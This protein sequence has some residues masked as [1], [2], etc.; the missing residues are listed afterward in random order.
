[1]E[2]AYMGTGT[3]MEK[4]VNARLSSL[5]GAMAIADL[6]KT[7]L[8]PKGMDKILQSVDPNDQSISVTNDGA[9]ILSKIPLDNAAAKV[10]V[11]M[12]KV[13]DN[14]VG[15]GTTSVAVLC[16]E[17]LR[18]AEQLLLQQRIHPQTICAG[19]RLATKE[20]K[21]A[22]ESCASD[23]ITRDDLLKIASTTLSSKL[24]NAEKKHFAELC[25]SAVE[26]LKGSG[27]LDHIQIIKLPGGSMRDSYLEDGFLL[28][29]A[30]GVGQPKRLENCKIL[31]GNTSMDT[32]KIKI[33]GSRV[34]VDSLNKVAE[35]EQAEKM[36]MKKKVDKIL[37]HGCNV[38]INRQLIYNYPESLFAQN[39]VIAIEHADF[40]GIERLAAVTGG[41]VVSTFDNPDKVTLGE[42][43]V[44][45]E[46]LIG[47]SK[48]LRLGGCKSGAACTV[49]LRGSSNH[50][51]DEAER[52]LHDALCILMAT[53]KHPRR[54][55]GGGCTEVAMAH[56]IDKAAQETPGKQAIAMT[57]FAK[58][59]LQLP[60]IVAD[61]GGYDAA[62]L[63]TQL[64]A[65]HAAGKNSYGLNMT[66]GTIG[67]MDELGVM[68]SFKSKL[69]VLTSAAEAAEM[70]LRVDDIIKSAPRRREEMM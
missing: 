27:N 1:M 37:A 44:L 21:A 14:E 64:R 7:T 3:E 47:E 9:T 12:S 24:V 2:S 51:L 49:V 54:I 58:A 19:W 48:I 53:L 70:I 40:D 6:V 22:L 13:Q 39:K 56:A 38:F 61:N 34:Q 63:V 23:D 29:K 5:I 15:D 55:Y 20:A 33:Y 10:L 68:E 60:M 11:D 52:S 35:I 41:E 69:Q 57:S 8:G 42:C 65:A 62:E 67:S 31:L 45:E 25:V 46:I 50:L 59:L 17:L 66:N 36:K 32:D 28:E 26:R 30:I 16:G 43:D 18:E 4:G